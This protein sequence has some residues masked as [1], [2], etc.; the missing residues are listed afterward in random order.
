M[1]ANVSRDSLRINALMRTVSLLIS[2]LPEE[3]K[4]KAILVIQSIIKQDYKQNLR[5][6]YPSVT[7][8]TADE[9]DKLQTECYK[10]ILDAILNFDA[11][12][13]EH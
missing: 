8:E 6:H 5:S 7:E 9:F 10:E 4:N 1:N 3:E 12:V 11:P 2:L 13:E